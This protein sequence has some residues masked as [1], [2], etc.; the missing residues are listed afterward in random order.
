MPVDVESSWVTVDCEGIHQFLYWVQCWLAHADGTKM[1]WAC[2]YIFPIGNMPCC[3]VNC[4]LSGN[5]A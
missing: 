2:L 4:S 5:T 1:Q 3:R